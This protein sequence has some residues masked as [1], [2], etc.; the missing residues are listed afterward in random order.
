MIR[1]FQI[2]DLVAATEFR[3]MSLFH[4]FVVCKADFVFAQKEKVVSILLKKANWKGI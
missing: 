2:C 4:R 1:W 3:F